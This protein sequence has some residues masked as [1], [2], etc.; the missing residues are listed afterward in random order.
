M[1]T[2]TNRTFWPTT[3]GAVAFQPGWFQGHATAYLYV[4][5]GFGT[6]GPDGGPQNMSN[7]MVPPFQLIG[8]SKNPYP[9]TVCLPQVPLPQGATVKAGDN[10]T[11]QV[12]ELAV[13]GAAL[14]SVSSSSLSPLVLVQETVPLTFSALPSASTSPLSS[15]TTRASKRSTRATASTATTSA[16][17]TSTPSPTAPRAPTTSRAVPRRPSTTLAAT[18]AAAGCRMPGGCRRWWV[19]YGCLCECGYGDCGQLAMKQSP[20]PALYIFGM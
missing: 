2:T 9:G 14:Y 10:A 7:P 15:Q 13:H 16:S 17:P 1:S 5:L 12:V 4:N 11:I 20:P 8:P 18:A 6:D 19:G 3:G